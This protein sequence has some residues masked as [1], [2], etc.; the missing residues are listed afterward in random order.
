[1]KKGDIVNFYTSN[2]NWVRDYKGRNPGVVLAS[3]EPNGKYY[4][5]GHAYV[6]WADGCITREH[7]TYLKAAENE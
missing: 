3:Q 2:P 1:M 6:L 4:D 7:L 5:K